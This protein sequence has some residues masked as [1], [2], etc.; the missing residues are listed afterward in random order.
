M[1]AKAVTASSYTGV[2]HT[3]C[4]AA[5]C[6]SASLSKCQARV[7]VLL[8]SLL[9]SHMHA[10]SRSLARPASPGLLPWLQSTGDKAATLHA[11]YIPVDVR[12]C[13]LW[14]AWVVY[15]K[16]ACMHSRCLLA[17][18]K[19]GANDDFAFSFE[20]QHLCCLPSQPQTQL[21]SRLLCVCWACC[22]RVSSLYYI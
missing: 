21:L 14:K 8:L 18:G 4:S 11:C 2:C 12:V 1:Q 6:L 3:Q 17:G 22:L 13:V 16:W 19:S 20:Q 9:S 10:A 7:Q 5:A 15:R